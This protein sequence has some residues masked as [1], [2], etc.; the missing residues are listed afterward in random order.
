ML[1]RLFGSL[2]LASAAAIAQT[3][4]S[5]PGAASRSGAGRAGFVVLNC[6]SISKELQQFG[7]GSIETGT[8]D[9]V[10]QARYDDAARLFLLAGIDA[11]FDDDRAADPGADDGARTLTRLVSEALTPAQM[12][13]LVRTTHDLMTT[14]ES[15]RSLCATIRR[16]GPPDVVA[17]HATSSA[18]AAR[19]PGQRLARNV[20]ADREWATLTRAYLD[21]PA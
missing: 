19:T 11:R 16:I 3:T 2:L 15:H 14:D 9:C 7:A 1:N 17:R 20:D 12:A 5:A 13:E 21:C 10:R 6:V 8:L 18:P 4:P